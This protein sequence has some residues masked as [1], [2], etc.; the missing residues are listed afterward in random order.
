MAATGEGWGEADVVI[1]SEEK[2]DLGQKKGVRSDGGRSELR[3]GQAGTWM[4]VSDQGG[5]MRKEPGAVLSSG[6]LEF[7]ESF[8]Q[9][10]L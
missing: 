6:S 9:V 2:A 8:C 10:V 3:F 1:D 7:L 4:S 5:V